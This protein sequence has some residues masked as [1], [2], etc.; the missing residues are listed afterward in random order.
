MLNHLAPVYNN[1][2][3]PLAKSH[4]EPFVA[5]Y[6]NSSHLFN[7]VTKG[8]K[9]YGQAVEKNFTLFKTLEQAT[10]FAVSFFLYQKGWNLGRYYL[11]FPGGALALSVI[12]TAGCWVD[13]QLKTNM[14]DMCTKTWLYY[15]GITNLWTNRDVTFISIILAGPLGLKKSSEVNHAWIAKRQYAAEWLAECFHK[16]PLDKAPNNLLNVQAVDGCQHTTDTE[17]K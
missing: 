1:I 8:S 16:K 7:L 4:I 13:S 5:L 12:Y 6:N 9:D 3:C 2:L 10:Y 14:T 11:G 15:Q 17:S